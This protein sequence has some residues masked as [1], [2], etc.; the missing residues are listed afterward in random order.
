MGFY[1]KDEIKER[2]TTN[3]I[4]DLLS[5]WGG[6][7]IITSFGIISDTI[8]HNNPGEGSKKLYYYSNTNLFKCYTGCD[9]IFDIFELTLKVYKI[10]KNIELKLNEAVSI[11]ANKFGFSSSY[12]S[13]ENDFIYFQKDW[14][15]FSNYERIEELKVETSE[16]ILK[17]YDI[18]ILKYFNYKIKLTPWLKEGIDEKIIKYNK[19][20][21]YSGEESITIPHFD[22]NNRFIGLR[23]RDLS[24]ENAKK[25]GKYK[26]LKI[27]QV[28]YS[29]PLGMN[30]YNLNNAKNNINKIQKAIIFE[31]EKSTLLYQTYFGLENDISVA[32]CGSS[33]SSYQIQML[34]KEGAKEIVIAFDRQFQQVGDEE[35]KHLKR[36]LLRLREKYKN[37]VII[38]F[39]F[40]KDMILGYKDSPIDCGK[41]NFLKLFKERIIL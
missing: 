14:E 13:K 36:N 30:L 35:F 9:E 37:Y 26:P 7:P 20:G 25:Y 33:I 18:N 31:G 29:H 10:Q 24:K 39:I 1:D 6:Q 38:S 5:L 22:K 16:I 11:I 2:L 32:C 34:I 19:I 17:E 12:I 3:D 8:C 15:Y 21:F 41:D 23:G 28:T 4:Y 27:N 40:D